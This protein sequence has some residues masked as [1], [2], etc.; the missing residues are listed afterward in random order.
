M[1]SRS[2]G[3]ASFL[4]HSLHPAPLPLFPPRFGHYGSHRG[5]DFTFSHCCPASIPWATP[6]CR[7][8]L[9][10]W[11]EQC[12]ASVREN[13]RPAWRTSLVVTTVA[14]ARRVALQRVMPPSQTPP[15]VASRHLYVLFYICTWMWGQVD[16]FFVFVK[17]NSSLGTITT[18]ILITLNYYYPYLL[19]VAPVYFDILLFMLML[20]CVALPIDRSSGVFL[21]VWKW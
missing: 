21:T 19:P 9:V 2:E 8:D 11:E 20:C 17:K 15:A 18:I 3:P 1:T 10:A 14:Q 5:R 12:D 6:G 7:E 13:K 16:F 4:P